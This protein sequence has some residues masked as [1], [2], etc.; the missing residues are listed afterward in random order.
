MPIGLEARLYEGDG[1]GSAWKEIAETP[2]YAEPTEIRESG[3]RHPIISRH[4]GVLIDRFN[5][6]TLI[7][8]WPRARGN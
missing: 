7:S 5:I 1:G 4:Y 8:F 6:S 3:E 2:S